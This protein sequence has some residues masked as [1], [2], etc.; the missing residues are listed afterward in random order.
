MG[1]CR[2]SNKGDGILEGSEPFE[3]PDFT[4][5]EPAS[6][7]KP[8]SSSSSV[9]AKRTRL[10]L[11]VELAAQGSTYKDIGRE[12]NLSDRQ[13][14]RDV[15]ENGLRAQIDQRRVEAYSSLC[16]RFTERM[17]QVDEALGDL[18]EDSDPKIK[19]R[20][21]TIVLN[22]TQRMAESAQKQDEA[23][24]REE[25]HYILAIKRYFELTEAHMSPEH[26]QKYTGEL[27]A[28]P[29]LQEIYPDFDFHADHLEPQAPDA[30]WPE[31]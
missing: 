11:I 27:M 23:E 10:D 8:Q 26:Y 4:N 9:E 24:E 28:D 1:A 5:L 21:V 20:G 16:G 29:R 19:A 30:T 14:R 3:A 12:V 15:A 6:S 18:L 17:A 31:E 13:V 22:A 7:R 2:P 25:W